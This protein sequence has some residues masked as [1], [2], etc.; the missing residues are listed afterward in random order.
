M[1]SDNWKESDVNR[2]RIFGESILGGFWGRGS[3]CSCTFA[4][5]RRDVDD[6]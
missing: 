3:R 4:L 2:V 5:S 6:A 1:D